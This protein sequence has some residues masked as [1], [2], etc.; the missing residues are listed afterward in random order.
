MYA[1]EPSLI[2]TIYD[3]YCLKKTKMIYNVVKVSRSYFVY[4]GIFMQMR[5]FIIYIYNI[6]IHKLL[7]KILKTLRGYTFRY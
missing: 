3:Q 5:S 7:L 1:R 6:K 2:F 4:K